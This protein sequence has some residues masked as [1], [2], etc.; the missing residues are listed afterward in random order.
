M[1][2]ASPL[3]IFTGD[4]EVAHPG[5]APG[6]PAPAPQARK[7]RLGL[8][9]LDESF[10]ETLKDWLVEGLWPRQA[11][12]FIA[13]Q[14][15][16][17]KS[18][19]T[20]E[21]ALCLALGEPFLG[22]PVPSH[23]RIAYFLGEETKSDVA[24]RARKLLASKG[25]TFRDLGG[26][27]LL[28]S[29]VPCLESEERRVELA[30]ACT[31]ERID[32]VVFDPLE[33]FLG[34]GESNSSK[35]MRPVNN[36]L[37]QVLA[38]QC[39]TAV[40]VVH[41]TDK[42]GLSLR[43]TGD[44]LSISEVTMKLSRPSASGLVSVETEMRAAVAPAKFAFSVNDEPPGAV[45]VHLAGPGDQSTGDPTL[46]ARALLTEVGASGTTSDEAARRLHVRRDRVD[47]ALRNAGG[48]RA[49]GPRGRWILPAPGTDVSFPTSP[50]VN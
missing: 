6:I 43:G 38:R 21:M 10:K 32:L 16:A 4:T 33:R 41:H 45:R 23:G 13:G 14:P 40:C 28:S 24:A 1:S 30:Q 48:I 49:G 3:A 36:F 44:F 7:H 20:L 9:P 19:L 29:E 39:G 27:F 46:T 2:E 42:K 47:E 25:R 50:S 8:V 35:E 18:W 34:A 22:R 5:S 31:E 11:V 37:R 12:G 15:K 26:R 17:G